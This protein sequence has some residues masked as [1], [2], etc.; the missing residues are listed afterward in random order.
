MG[1]YFKEEII[2]ILNKKNFTEIKEISLL[3]NQNI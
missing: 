2:E 3:Y 1:E